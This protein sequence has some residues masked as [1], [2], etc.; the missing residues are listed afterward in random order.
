MSYEV[1]AR[2][3]GAAGAWVAESEDFPGLVAE[4]RTPNE[5]MAKLRALV[6]E[7]LELNGVLKQAGIPKQ[8]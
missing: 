6:R 7:L 5:L 8:F 1:S 4:A 2:W 3:D